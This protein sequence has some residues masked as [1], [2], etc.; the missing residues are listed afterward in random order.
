METLLSVFS[1]SLYALVPLLLVYGLVRI[2]RR[3]GLDDRH[4]P[5]TT[6]EDPDYKKY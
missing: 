6:D 3:F 2:G 1:L 5:G 4:Q